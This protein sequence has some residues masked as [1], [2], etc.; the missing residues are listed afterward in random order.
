MGN[1]LA[2]GDA[3]P[4]WTAVGFVPMGDEPNDFAANFGFGHGA[5][6][7]QGRHGAD[8]TGKPAAAQ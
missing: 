3:V 7:V 6:D 8:N 1:V 2:D 4:L 5:E